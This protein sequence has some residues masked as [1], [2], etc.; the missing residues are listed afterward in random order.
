MTGVTLVIDAA[1]IHCQC[2]IPSR[3]AGKPGQLPDERP[4]VGVQQHPANITDQHLHIVRHLAAESFHPELTA[5]GLHARTGDNVPGTPV[6]QESACRSPLRDE[7][8][9]KGR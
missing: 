1:L 5:T 8:P 2:H 9:R 7:P 3:P 4:I 6:L